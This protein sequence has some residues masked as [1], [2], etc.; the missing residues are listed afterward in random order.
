LDEKEELEKIKF[1]SIF[2][3]TQKELAERRK[4]TSERFSHNGMYHSGPHVRAVIGLH[5]NAT[6]KLLFS[7]L[8]VLFDVYG[9][10]VTGKDE[11]ILDSKIE[12]LFEHRT[13][14]TRDSVVRFQEEI[15]VPRITLDFFEREMSNV[16]AELKRKIKSTILSTKIALKE[17]EY[18]EAEMLRNH[19]RDIIS[20]NK[21]DG[22]II[23]N[24]RAFV[25]RDV[26]F[27]GDVNIP[28]EEGDI[29]T[30]ELPN[31]LKESLEV[32]DRGYM[33][34]RG[35][36]PAHYQVKVRRPTEKDTRSVKIFQAIGSNPKINVDSVDKSISISITENNV[37]DEL[38]KAILTGVTDKK[39]TKDLLQKISEL[40]S[41]QKTTGFKDKY[42]EFISLAADHMTLLS[43]FIQILTKLL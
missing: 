9:I 34:N 35:S 12:K 20:L 23:N 27:I 26:V 41:A 24:I 19:L 4:Q 28:V 16:H 1:I 8:D 36:I 30:R 21:K 11:Q 10:P 37:F 7:M 14:A 42:Q 22:R 29:I 43:P 31:G 39:L 25:Q 18:K 5:I 38:E 15:K 6:R 40:K 17:S 3:D 2:E 32:L 13:Q 33:P